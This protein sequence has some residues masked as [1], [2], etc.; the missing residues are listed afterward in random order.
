MAEGTGLQQHG[1]MRQCEHSPLD[2]FTRCLTSLSFSPSR[3]RAF[4]TGSRLFLPAPRQSA[5]NKKWNSRRGKIQAREG[6]KQRDSIN[7]ARKRKKGN[8]EEMSS[9]FQKAGPSL[10]AAPRFAAPPSCPST[11]PHLSPFLSFPPLPFPASSAHPSRS[12]CGQKPSPGAQLEETTSRTRRRRPQPSQRALSCFRQR[13]RRGRRLRRRWS[14]SSR[15]GRRRLGAGRSLSK[16]QSCCR[17]LLPLPLLPLQSREPRRPSLPA[18]PSP[19]PR[20]GAPLRSRSPPRGPTGPA[21]GVACARSGA[22]RNDKTTKEKEKEQKRGSRW[23]R[24]EAR[25]PACLL[26][27]ISASPA[28]VL[29]PSAAPAAAGGTAVVSLVGATAAPPV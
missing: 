25:R 29:G 10:P 8:A 11:A 5:K 17:L 19:R 23:R 22:G 6:R 7:C 26:V 2:V 9:K 4:C 27:V 18:A 28:A 1:G 13:G 15:A 3:A 16:E 21:R 20:R 24:R 14:Q 12:P